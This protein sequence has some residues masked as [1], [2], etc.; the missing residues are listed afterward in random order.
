MNADRYIGLYT[1]MI[2]HNVSR[3]STTFDCENLDE[4]VYVMVYQYSIDLAGTVVPVTPPSN[5]IFFMNILDRLD[6]HFDKN[7]VVSSSDIIEV[8]KQVMINYIPLDDILRE[9]I[10]SF[11][12]G[13]SDVSS[14]TSD[15]NTCVSEIES[16][17]DFVVYKMTRQKTENETEIDES[18]L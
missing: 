13:V 2:K 3:R 4:L 6:R 16:N 17:E 18:P 1:R 11:A 9:K 15:S 5:A 12:D 10:I 8:I 7:H 14:E